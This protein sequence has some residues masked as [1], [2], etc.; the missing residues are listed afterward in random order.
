[1]YRQRKP[2]GPSSTHWAP[3][4]KYGAAEFGMAAAGRVDQ[5]LLTMCLRLA[6]HQFGDQI[7]V[8]TG[9]QFKRHHK[10]RRRAIQPERWRI[11][12][13]GAQSGRIRKGCA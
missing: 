10:T 8:Q 11:R 12:R 13:Y 7:I 5:V 2:P 1:M 3:E 4:M 6:S 9:E